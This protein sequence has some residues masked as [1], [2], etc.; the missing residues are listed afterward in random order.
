MSD[1]E[2]LAKFYGELFKALKKNGFNKMEALR[3]ILKEAKVPRTKTARKEKDMK[4]LLKDVIEEQSRGKQ[5]DTD[6]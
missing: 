6:V 2:D 3:I 1:I 5:F 4:E